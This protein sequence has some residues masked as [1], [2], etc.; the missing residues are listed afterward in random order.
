MSRILLGPCAG[1]NTNNNTTT[2]IMDRH[3]TRD[4]RVPGKL[5]KERSLDSDLRNVEVARR[6]EGKNSWNV[7]IDSLHNDLVSD[8]KHTAGHVSLLQAG[9][10]PSAK[11]QVTPPS[12][13]YPSLG[14]ACSTALTSPAR[15]DE[16]SIEE[17][18]MENA[19]LPTKLGTYSNSHG[20]ATSLPPLR[21]PSPKSNQLVLRVLSKKP[22]ETSSSASDEPSD[23]DQGRSTVL[24]IG[25]LGHPTLPV[26]QLRII[27]KLLYLA[28]HSHVDVKPDVA[29]FST[30]SLS[31]TQMN[32][33]ITAGLMIRR[34]KRNLGE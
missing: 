34:Q 4:A 21:V 2:S 9:S 27:D 33:A 30:P 18:Q 14:R 31:T 13:A 3:I 29:S 19:H 26:Q 12:I 5:R 28:F 22:D 15:G 11:I 7:T 8:H 10:P 24:G 6:R 17:G 20:D 32:P 23:V 1:N 16:E 25:A